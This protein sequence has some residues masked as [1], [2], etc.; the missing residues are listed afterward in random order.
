VDTLRLEAH[1]ATQDGGPSTAI[2]EGARKARE[3]PAL[4]KLEGGATPAC[5]CWKPPDRAST[6]LDIE[7]SCP[8]S[9]CGV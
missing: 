6:P 3:I 9:D 4:L 1:I 8:P 7:G 5:R 2:R